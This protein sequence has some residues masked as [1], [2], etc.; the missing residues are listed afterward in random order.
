MKILLHVY[1][2]KCA[3]STF[4]WIL[5]KNFPNKVLYVKS[6]IEGSRLDFQK[7]SPLVKKNPYRSISSHL[8]S[9]P[10]PNVQQARLTI[11]LL[12]NPSERLMSAY[13]FQTSTQNLKVGNVNFQA[14]LP[15]RR[16][17]IISNY[18]TRLLSPQSWNLAD[19][20]KGW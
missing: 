14:F 10:Q 7:V 20:R 17:S 18:Q 1:G 19:S 12:R 16:Y 11:I 13:E 9:R 2:V 8:I 6:L 5:E 4:E 15:K 3:G